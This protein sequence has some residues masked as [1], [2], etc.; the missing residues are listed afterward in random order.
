M[1]SLQSQMKIQ[2]PYRDSTLEE[3]FDDTKNVKF[4]VQMK[5]YD[6]EKIEVRT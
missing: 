6:Q 5:N 3:L 1:H 4:K 2:T